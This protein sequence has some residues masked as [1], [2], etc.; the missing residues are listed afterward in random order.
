MELLEPGE[1]GEGWKGSAGPPHPVCLAKAL[2]LP[3]IPCQQ[4]SRWKCTAVMFWGALAQVS[5]LALTAPHGGV[6]VQH[7]THH[8]GFQGSQLS[9]AGLDKGIKLGIAPLGC[10]RPLQIVP[11]IAPA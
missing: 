4:L 9:C 11:V 1:A 8:T 7:H 3:L 5:G 2:P 10:P 6:S